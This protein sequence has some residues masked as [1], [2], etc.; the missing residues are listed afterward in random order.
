MASSTVRRRQGGGVPP[1]PPR[2]CGLVDRA[3]PGRRWVSP[4]PRRRRR[5]VFVRRQAAVGLLVEPSLS[6]TCLRRRRLVSRAASAD[7]A[8][9]FLLPLPLPSPVLVV[10]L[11]PCCLA[12]PSVSC[13]CPHRRHLV[14]VRRRAAVGLCGLFLLVAIVIAIAVSRCCSATMFSRRFVSG[15]GAE[16]LMGPVSSC[17]RCHG[18][19]SLLFCRHDVKAVPL[20][21]RAGGP[22]L[23]VRWLSSVFR[24]MELLRPGQPGWVLDMTPRG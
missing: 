24:W 16:V 3:A 13:T 2:R 10:I 9:L 19:F 14:S 8:V 5:L 7:R 4:P 6:C 23:R 15:L 20:P 1:H 21:S 11:P 12:E 22:E 17:C 18:R